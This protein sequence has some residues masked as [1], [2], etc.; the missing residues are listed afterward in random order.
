[1]RLST[2]Y[3]LFDLTWILFRKHIVLAPRLLTAGHPYVV[4]VNLLPPYLPQ[5]R[6]ETHIERKATQHDWLPRLLDVGEKQKWNTVV[7]GEK[8]CCTWLTRA[9]LAGRKISCTGAQR[10]NQRRSPFICTPRVTI[11]LSSV[12]TVSRLGHPSLF[13]LSKT[14]K[15]KF[16]N[17]D[18][19]ECRLWS[20]GFA[21]RSG[22]GQCGCVPSFCEPGRSSPLRAR[23]YC[24]A[25]S[26]R[27][28]SRYRWTLNSC[29]SNISADTRRSISTL[30]RAIQICIHLL[31]HR[32][33]RFASFPSPAG[34][35][36][37][38]SP[39]SGKMTS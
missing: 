27:Y 33:K 7:C 19:S 11:C 25:P 35:S 14:V 30:A 10:T 28:H 32:K 4:H 5:V 2:V 8:I 1:M 26:R 22:C 34:M 37:P 23:I 36:L 39:W 18:D 24:P 38:N 16:K 31:V 17:S 20:K 21:C 9:A 13:S 3:C 15:K 6:P 12:L 29:S